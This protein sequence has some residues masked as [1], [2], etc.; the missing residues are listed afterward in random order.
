MPVAG[1][2]LSGSCSYEI[3]TVA[4]SGGGKIVADVSRVG[5]STD[6]TGELTG[7]GFSLARGL[8][9]GAV[10][11]VGSGADIGSLCKKSASAAAGADVVVTTL[12]TLEI[13][14]L[15]TLDAENRRSRAPNASASVSV[16]SPPA[17]ISP[18]I[19]C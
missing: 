3:V 16:S 19:A 15:V 18:G 12:G 5:V 2:L 13:T 10:C 11:V 9:L 1:W 14:V 4:K 17:E 6:L 7:A 8:V